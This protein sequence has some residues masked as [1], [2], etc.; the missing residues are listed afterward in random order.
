MGVPEA[1]HNT[2]V[3]DT[4]LR[5]CMISKSTIDL[6]YMGFGGDSR[7]HCECVQPS[8][9]PYI[10]T[11]IYIYI[12]HCNGQWDVMSIHFIFAVGF[13]FWVFC[14][15]V[16]DL[17]LSESIEMHME[18]MLGTYILIRFIAST[19]LCYQCFVL[20]QWHRCQITIRRRAKQIIGSLRSFWV[21]TEIS[22]NLL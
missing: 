1:E 6:T 13:C 16:Q 18:I 22:K 4:L 8:I 14:F 20:F 11:N 12:S 17:R 21:D 15:L 9:T 7:R 10:A 2:S 19:A 5:G 3:L